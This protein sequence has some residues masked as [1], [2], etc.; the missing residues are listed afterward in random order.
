MKNRFQKPL[1]S[2]TMIFSLILLVTITGCIKGKRCSNSYSFTHSVA[3]YPVQSSYNVGDTIWFDMAVSDVFE[4]GVTD[5]TGKKHQETVHLT[6][7]YFDRLYASVSEI[8]NGGGLS[9]ALGSFTMVTAAGMVYDGGNQQLIFE[10]DYLNSVYV[11]KLGL[12]CNAPGVFVY[13]SWFEDQ[14]MGAE[15]PK[16]DLNISSDCSKEFIERITFPVNKQVDGTYLN[17]SG[18]LEQYPNV[19]AHF[20]SLN[21]GKGETYTFVVN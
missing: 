7:F 2:V 6:D 3:V 5:R 19:L 1:A 15:G 21:K 8:V 18:I 13:T 4:V 16:K 12:V 11:F 20:L 14:N 9:N 10:Y 17:N